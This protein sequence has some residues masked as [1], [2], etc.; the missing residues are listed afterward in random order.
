[1]ENKNLMLQGSRVLKL[2]NQ[3]N[4]QKAKRKRDVDVEKI[5]VDTEMKSNLYILSF[6]NYSRIYN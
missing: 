6:I 5:M 1:M 4:K 2:K 3:I